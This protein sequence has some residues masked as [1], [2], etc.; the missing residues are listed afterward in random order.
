MRV[1]KNDNDLKKYIKETFLEVTDARV[2]DDH[3]DLE[4]SICKVAR[5]FQLTKRILVGH[6][7]EY[8]SFSIDYSAPTT[9]VFRC[10][11]CHTFKQWIIYELYFSVGT[12]KSENHY[13]RVTSVPNEGLED[14]SE[15]PED[16]PSLRIAYRQAIRAMDANANIAAAAMF[17]RALQVITRELLG[18]KPGNLANE[19]NEVVGKSYHGS[20]ITANFADI[21]YVIKEGGNQGSHP[22]RDP[23]L[24]DFTAQDATDLQLIFMELVSE[25]FIVPAA[26]QKAKQDFMARRKIN[27]P[28]G[29]IIL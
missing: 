16:P 25:L 12:G 22:D 26:K 9:Y 1:F 15:L 10:P 27:P 20:A 21:G 19:L 24:L 4:C 13:Y 28:A 5:G 3:W 29:K 18:A 2:D 11:V 23:D 14:I 8:E 7:T 6:Q 17:R